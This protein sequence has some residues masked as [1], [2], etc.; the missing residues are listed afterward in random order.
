[1]QSAMVEL[2]NHPAVLAKLSGEIDSVVGSSRLVNESDVPN[3]PYLQAIVKETLRLHTPGALLRRT[4]SA[5]CKINGY[6]V[7]AGT[8]IL[9][10]AHAI[11][12]DPDTWTDPNRF[13]HSCHVP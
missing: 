4:C 6:D 1:M 12:H 7:K 10:N 9:V 8:K 3:L 2:F 13:Y 5:D 11:M